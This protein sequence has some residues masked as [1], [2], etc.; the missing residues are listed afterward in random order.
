MK[1]GFISAG[2]DKK[3]GPRM[4]KFNKGDI[5]VARLKRRGY[6]GVGRIIQ[7]AKRIREVEIEGEKL[8]DLDLKCKN[9]FE[10]S[11][12]KEKSEYVALVKWIK[13]VPREQ[14]KWKPN[15][16]LYAPQHIRASLDNQPK[17]I[18]FVEK[19]FNLSIKKLII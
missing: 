9:M 10:N 7:T 16:D 13:A 4:L 14:A 3:W 6:V 18:E 12:N 15:S 11:N 19:E 2:Q 8:S 5:I 17:T 1:Y